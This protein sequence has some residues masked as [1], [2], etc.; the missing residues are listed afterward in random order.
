MQEVEVKEQA[1]PLVPVQNA[2]TEFEKVSAGLV[3]LTRK[4]AN[5]V[6]PVSTTKGMDEAKAAR[7][8][9]RNVRYAV[10]R[11]EKSASDELNGI[12]RNVKE[13]AEQIIA[14]LE[15]I[16]SPIDQQIKAE[17]DRKAEEK[18]KKE[19]AEAARVSAI[20]E[21][22]AAI[23]AAPVAVAGMN[24]S[25]IKQS[26]E[27]LSQIQI[28]TSFDEF[29][30]E[31]ANAKEAAVATLIVMHD[32]AAESE[33]AAAE[34]KAQ[35]EEL[36]RMRA[37]IERE[38]KELEEAKAQAES[39][40]AT[41]ERARQEA[42]QRQEAE[43]F[44]AAREAERLAKAEQEDAFALEQEQAQQQAAADA[45]ERRMDLRS[46]AGEY[47]AAGVQ[48]LRF[49]DQT[50][51]AT[52]LTPETTPASTEMSIESIEM[53]MPGMPGSVEIVMA[54][55]D[56][57]GVSMETAWQWIREINANEVDQAIAEAA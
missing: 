29:L 22:I 24:A 42:F 5:V 35:Q 48:P 52:M 44:A 27:Q 13:R 10:Q 14:V 41:E 26:L 2:L 17:E 20:R 36:A 3:D 45:V 31:A 4:Y 23:T 54:V 55:G 47:K 39:A 18:R 34:L 15:P 40:R 11:A 25:A 9:I 38:R 49:E 6:Y 50:V 32:R 57:Y 21:R 51:Q 8:E 30:P 19:E 7:L 43:R 46:I 56:Y 28:D 1:G 33:R 37:Q 16:E 53:V 12:K